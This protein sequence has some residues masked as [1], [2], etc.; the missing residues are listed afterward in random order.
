MFY[1]YLDSFLCVLGNFCYQ[2]FFC[3]LPVKQLQVM[4]EIYCSYTVTIC[5]LM[6]VIYE[7]RDYDKKSCT[8]CSARL[9]HNGPVRFQ[10]LAGHSSLPLNYKAEIRTRAQI[11]VCGKIIAAEHVQLLNINV[12]RHKSIKRTVVFFMRYLAGATLSNE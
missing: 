4:Y 3:K 8:V 2:L 9:I 12:L 6:K 5:L 10:I 11:A 1:W 7:I